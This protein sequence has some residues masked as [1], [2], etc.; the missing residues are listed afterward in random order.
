MR[1]GFAHRQAYEKYLSVFHLVNWRLWLTLAFAVIAAACRSEDS[2]S[3]GISGS[4]EYE[5]SGEGFGDAGLG[6]GERAS[7]SGSVDGDDSADAAAAGVTGAMSDPNESG[8]QAADL[9]GEDVVEEAAGASGFGGSEFCE[10]VDGGAVCE[11]DAGVE[12]GLLGAGESVA[13]LCD[14]GEGMEWFVVDEVGLPAR[15]LTDGMVSSDWSPDRSRLAY[16]TAGALVVVNADGSDQQTLVEGVV[17][18]PSWSGNGAEIAYES[19]AD[20]DT[21]SSRIAVVSLNGGD[22]HEFVRGQSPQWASDGD[23]I[24]Y[25]DPLGCCDSSGDKLW[26]KSILDPYTGETYT[27]G[28][29]SQDVHIGRVNALWSPDGLYVAYSYDDNVSRMGF[30]LSCHGE[31]EHPCVEWYGP[32]WQEEWP[33]GDG[34]VVSWSPDARYI[35]HVKSSDAFCA[36]TCDSLWMTDFYGFSTEY[37]AGLRY[38]RDFEWSPGGGSIAFV[39]EWAGGLKLLEIVS[40]SESEEF[41]YPGS[42][43]LATSGRHEQTMIPLPGSFAPSWSADGSRLAF[44]SEDVEYDDLEDDADIYIAR[45]DTTNLVRLTQDQYHNISPL[46]IQLPAQS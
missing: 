11:G 6:A 7:E 21:Q 29:K 17:S 38:G 23:L 2:L 20:A 19:Q 33:L 12:L 37:I 4:A 39:T 45:T 41:P 22:P 16:T 27:I 40:V 8:E 24:M 34:R 26:V 14:R 5:G 42:Q 3:A 28:G 43:E 1:H 15:Q 36:G 32:H 10:P 46:W 9:V 13:F 31:P 35:A 30:D 25:D 18:S 44:A